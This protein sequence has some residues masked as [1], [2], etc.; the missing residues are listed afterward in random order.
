MQRVGDHATLGDESLPVE[1]GYLPMS[2]LA[3]AAAALGGVSAL[4]LAS[5]VFWVLPLVAIGIAVAALRDAARPE[6]PKAGRL[7]AVAGLALATGFGAQAVAA[8]A[9]AR[10]IT[11]ARAA[12]AARLWLDTIHEQR[13]ADARSMCS[14]DAIAAI[15][16]VAACGASD[17]AGVIGTSAGDSEGNWLVRATVGTCTVEIMLEPT[18]ATWQ[19]RTGERWMIAN[20]EVVRPSAN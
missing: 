11:A 7:A 9:T 10:S 20:A 8:K 15:E 12:A 18:P 19:G 4:A 1:P 6:A 2:R 16:A 3:V 14:F 5:P 17:G 13:L